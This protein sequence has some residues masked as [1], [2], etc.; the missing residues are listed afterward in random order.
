MVGDKDDEVDADTGGGGALREIEIEDNG[1]SIVEK[2]TLVELR[3]G[4]LVT[5]CWLIS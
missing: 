5:V 1:E 3:A 4:K 2:V